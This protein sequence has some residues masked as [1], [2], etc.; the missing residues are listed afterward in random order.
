M[1]NFLNNNMK[2][3]ELPSQKELLDIF[4]YKDGNLYWKKYKQGVRKS[5]LAGAKNI[6]NYIRVTYKSKRY[7]IHR[8]IFMMHNG[9]C[10]EYI[11]HIDGNQLNNKIEN[12][13]EATI[14]ENSQNQKISK[15]N[16]SG[17]KGVTLNKYINKW[18]V[19]VSVNKKRLFLGYYDDLETAEFVANETRIKHH[20]NFARHK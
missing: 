14:I 19:R 20:K 15:N 2:I 7:L 5:K 4:E 1:M 3:A 11:D 10:S 17:I 6:D 18:L 13:R 8:I 16:T 9:F 12:L